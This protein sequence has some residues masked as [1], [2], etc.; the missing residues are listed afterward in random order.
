MYR[1]SCSSGRSR[2][3]ERP[4]LLDSGKITARSAMKVELLADHRVINGAL[5]AE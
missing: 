1:S 4:V 3:L 2:A 5:A